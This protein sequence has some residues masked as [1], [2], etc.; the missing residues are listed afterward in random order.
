MEMSESKVLGRIIA[1]RNKQRLTQEWMGEELGISGATY[2]RIESG[3]IALSYKH[4]TEIASVFKMS[5]LDIL[6]YPEIYSTRKE[7]IHSTKVMVEFDVS[8]DEFLKLG[9]KDK[10]LQIIDKN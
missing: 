7:E 9:L 6:T 1:I 8:N 10:V 3:K 2:S 4:L 5:V